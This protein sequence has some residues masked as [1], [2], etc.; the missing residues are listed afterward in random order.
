MVKI[1]ETIIFRNVVQVITGKV[2][3]LVVDYTL[4]AIVLFYGV[5]F[6]MIHNIR[7]LPQAL[8]GVQV[9]VFGHSHKYFE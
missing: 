8:G 7:N 4:R 2:N 3:T 5:R 6:L 9:N 1:I